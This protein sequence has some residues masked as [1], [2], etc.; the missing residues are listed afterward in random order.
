MATLGLL[1]TLVVG[2][3]AS[4]VAKE[5]DRI[6]LRASGLDVTIN[7][8]GTGEYLLTMSNRDRRPTPF[9]IDPISLRQ[10]LER[11]TPFRADSGSTEE[12]SRQF[13]ASNC[14]A[15]VPHVT[16]AGVIS[17]RW[18]GR[19]LDRIYIADFGCDYRRNAARN[20]E[21]RAILESLPVPEPAPFP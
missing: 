20:I 1:A 8:D 12:T 15:N 4:G 16:D 7:A 3:G 14:P 2:C 17:I 13:L 19:D 9:K 21:L 11:L 5:V 6:E 10:L 18:I